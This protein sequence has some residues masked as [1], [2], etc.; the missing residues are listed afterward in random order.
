MFP[1]VREA[2]AIGGLGGASGGDQTSMFVQFVPLVLIFVIFW[3]LVIRPQQKKSKEHRQMIGALKKGDDVYTD[4][5]IRGTIVNRVDENQLEVTLEIA[6][7]VQIRV[8]RARVG[9]M[10]K[11]GKGEDKPKESGGEAA[12]KDK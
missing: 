10:V 4:S 11:P 8:L 1:F 5:G 2:M 7:K 9:D 12:A 3:F 6:P